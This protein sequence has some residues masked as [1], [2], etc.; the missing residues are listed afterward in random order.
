MRRLGSQEIRATVISFASF[1]HSSLAQRLLSQCRANLYM[2]LSVL[3]AI[4]FRL[5]PVIASWPYAVGFDTT[6]LYVPLM[7]SGPPSAYA[8]FTY[9]GLNSLII[10]VGYQLEKQ[11]FLILDSIALILQ[12]G[13]AFSAYTYARSVVFLD[14][15][16]AFLTSAVFTLSPITLRL[17]WDQYRISIC[18][19]LVMGALAAMLSRSARVRILIIPLTVLVVLTN[20]LPSVFLLLTMIVQTLY[21]YVRKRPFRI[22]L[23]TS[24]IGS[25]IFAVQLSFLAASGL[26]S[27]NVQ[28]SILG[29][30]G[31]ASQALSGIAFLIFTSW[32]LL[33]FLPFVFRI[34]DSSPEAIWLLLIAFFAVGLL[35]TG[36]YTIP[37]PFIYFMA[38]FPLSMFAGRALRTY[39]KFR[40]FRLVFGVVLVFLAVNAA[41]YLISSP[42]SPMGYMALGQPFRYYMPTGYLQSTI[43]I[44]YQKD[45]MELLTASMA[46]LPKDVTLYLPRQFYGLALLVPNVQQL[47]LVDIGEANPWLPSPFDSI[48][49]RGLSFTIWFVGGSG[50]YGVHTLPLNFEA[51]QTQGQFVLYQIVS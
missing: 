47:L 40:I 5:L 34:R 49:P 44:S 2:V 10:W 15:K 37:P 38:S 39:G 25:V 32:P 17:T 19:I 48:T 18:M 6:A 27:T 26:L 14:E 11:P 29:P 30:V 1:S 51:V 7:V 36:I 23:I 16:Y 35:T 8:I 41:A 33:I 43:P 12:A 28:L 46:A 45:L 42:L 3:L 4:G 31:G 9:P 22:A 24:M 21:A 13:L 20:P 50:W